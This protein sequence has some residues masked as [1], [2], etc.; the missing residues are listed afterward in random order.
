MAKEPK[1]NTV[2]RT[3]SWDDNRERNQTSPGIGQI[4]PHIKIRFMLILYVSNQMEK[5][6]YFRKITESKITSL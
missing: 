3:G 1:H 5:C 4:V 2:T 6:A